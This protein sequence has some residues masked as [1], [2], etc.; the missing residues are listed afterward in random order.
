MGGPNPTPGR[1]GERET[2]GPRGYEPSETRLALPLASGIVLLGLVLA[3]VVVAAGV[4]YALVAYEDAGDRAASPTVDSP[5]AAADSRLQPDTP[6][7]VNALR[8]WEDSLLS[9]YGWVDR[10]NGFVRIP[11][12]RAMTLLAADGLPTRQEKGRGR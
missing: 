1:D 9:T 2:G 3:A 11:L 10:E 8:A 7:Q 12:K 6:D 4:Y 5:H